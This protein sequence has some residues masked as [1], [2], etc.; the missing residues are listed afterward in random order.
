MSELRLSEVLPHERWSPEVVHSYSGLRMSGSISDR[1]VSD[2]FSGN[3]T[4]IHFLA[5][6]FFECTL[7]AASGHFERSETFQKLLSFW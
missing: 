1:L 7:T 5:F 4:H 6:E 3:A 2:N